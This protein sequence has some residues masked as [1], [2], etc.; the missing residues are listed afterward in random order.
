[1]GRTVGRPRKITPE[2]KLKLADFIRQGITIKDACYAVRISPSTF[3]RERE[4]DMEFD[5][6]IVEATEGGW[7]NAEALAKYHYRGYKR[8]NPVKLPPLPEIA[9]RSPLNASQGHSSVAVEPIQQ[10]KQPKTYLGLPVR[11]TYP[12]Q[13]PTDFY[14]NGTTNRVERFTKEG[15][16]Q[17]MS[18]DTWER[19]YLHPEQPLEF[20]WVF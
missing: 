4:R 5:K 11:F 1:M 19:K 20:G 7:T 12:E 2:V 6:L 18:A 14:Y 3:N 8:K 9:L 16:L 10:E 13:Y 17:T 15:V